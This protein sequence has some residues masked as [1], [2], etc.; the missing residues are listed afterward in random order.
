MEIRIPE[1]LIPTQPNLSELIGD[2]WASWNLDL[3]SSL[4]RI[5]ISQRTLKVSTS[6]DSGLSA[7]TRPAAFIRTAARGS[8]EWWAICH[9]ALFYSNANVDPRT[10]FIADGTAN[11]PTTALDY[12]Y[13]DADEFSGDLMVSLKTDIARLIAGTWSASYWITTLGKRAMVT[14]I[15]HPVKTIFNNLFLVGD[16]V[17]TNNE[18]GKGE[19]AGQAS[20]H[21]IDIAANATLNRLVFKKSL[22]VS[23]ILSSI[24]E[25]WIGLSHTAGGKAEM[26]YWD[27]NSISFNKNYKISDSVLCGGVIDDDG[28]PNVVDGKGRLLKFN[29]RAFKEI[30]R[31]PVLN[32]KY[33]RWGSGADKP[34]HKN[35]I[36]LI[37]G[38]INMLIAAGLNS[39]SK[40][41][42][43]NFW[44]GIWEYDENIGLYHKHG[45]TNTNTAG[46]LDFGSPVIRR[47]GALTE[48]SKIYGTFVAGGE[49]PTDNDTTLLGVI[50]TLDATD[51][52]LKTGFLMTRKFSTAVL[53]EHWERIA[54]TF[55]KLLNTTDK[56]YLKY[57]TD[58]SN[59]SNP[60]WKAATWATTTTF[61][62]ANSQTWI[63]VSVGDEVFILAGKGAG[64]CAKISALSL[65]VSTWTITLEHHTF[66]GIAITDTILVQ[67][68]NWKTLPYSSS[69]DQISDQTLRY[70]DLPV[71]DKSSEMQFKMVIFG[72]GDSP[73]INS[74]QLKSVENT[75]LE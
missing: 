18:G 13:S 58:F 66:T 11:S 23:F 39:D 68:K 44:S 55:S 21:S 40:G 28:I 29:G 41:G 36:S 62:S 8:D 60:N 1:K 30:A 37:D 24:D 51:T 5:K 73:E 61:T 25:V 59:Y 15:P 46:V 34:M 48:T 38:R 42:M 64:V 75:R 32:N 71:G 14:S 65:S 52:T 22:K 20:V 72:K 67:V 17:V 63:D 27:G 31:F 26:V 3:T 74:L 9:Q 7:L 6:S 2:M 45:L 12:E 57:R 56:I 43:E 19:K 47:P 4:G 69:Q 53:E 49:I 35:G 50:F 16:Q 33:Y 70:Q 54:I 10:A